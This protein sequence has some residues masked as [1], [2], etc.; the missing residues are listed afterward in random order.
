MALYFDSISEQLPPFLF[1]S[2]FSPIWMPES[3]HPPPP[4]FKSIHPF[5]ITVL[6]L[7]RQK[8]SAVMFRFGA[9]SDH[10]VIFHSIPIQLSPLNSFAASCPFG[11]SSS[12]PHCLLI[13]A[14]QFPKCGHYRMGIF[15]PWIN[16]NRELLWC[17]FGIKLA[18]I[19]L[20]FTKMERIFLQ[21]TK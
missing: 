9:A 14:G 3:V 8:R 21:N 2:S 17:Q 16:A 20:E 6:I 18:I 13:F 7:R 10:K 11:H 19:F 12:S 1:P 15:G 5:F 4:S